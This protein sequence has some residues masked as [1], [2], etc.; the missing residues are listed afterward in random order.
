[1]N[2]ISA[3]KELAV[4][5]RPG[6]T[7]NFT[8]E[9][10]EINNIDSNLKMI[11]LDK[12]TNTQQEI[13]VGS[14]YSFSSDATATNNRFSILFKSSS[15]TTGLNNSSAKGD[16][17]VYRNA[18]NQITVVCSTNINDGSLVSV[19]DAIG[20]Q[21]IQQKLTSTVSEINR[22]FT[23][24]VYIVTVNKGEQKITKKIIIN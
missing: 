4:G 12:L 3:T 20:Q 1:M 11:L 16:V 9:A 8:I 14:P 15:I 23:A 10:T 24:G 21:L 17:L 22:V 13:K 19:Y 18:T 6:K 2:T 7:G 5:F